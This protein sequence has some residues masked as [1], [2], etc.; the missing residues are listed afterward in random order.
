[1]RVLAVLVLVMKR[2]GDRKLS[3][4][5]GGISSV[6]HRIPQ[7]RWARGACAVAGTTDRI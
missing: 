6:I 3:V 1:M 7:S 2:P 4:A 5:D